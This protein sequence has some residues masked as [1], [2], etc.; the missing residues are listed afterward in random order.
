MS[1]PIRTILILT[2]ILAIPA[3]I[4]AQE[5]ESPAATATAT[6]TATAVTE[7]AE[8]G[9][10]ESA[11]ANTE[12]TVVTSYE[13]RE[14]FI[15]LLRQSPPD[16]VSILQLD[17]TLLS[18]QGFMNDYP[19][20]LAFV[21]T[22]P[23]VRR[24]PRFYVGELRE[25][26]PRRSLIGEV[27]ESLAIIGSLLL[28]AFSL[29]WFIRTVNEQK[30]WNRLFKTQNEVHNKILDRF[31]STDELLTYIKTPAGSKFLEA[32][33]IALHAERTPQSN[34]P[35]TRVLWSIQIGVVLAATAV[36]MLFV[37]LR[38]DPES[39]RE[40]F[41]LGMIAFFVGAGFI[42]SA[43]ASIFLSRRLGL[44]QDPQ[45]NQVPGPNPE[46]DPGL[47]R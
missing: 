21:E 43:V 11:E 1:L 18:N 4:H 45:S 13:I 22:H 5:A 30:R 47:M 9:A 3:G 35:M 19:E 40:L 20:L 25:P 34:P 42:G 44:W 28:A 33:P 27:I 6:E 12:Q 41:A 32:A 23:E 17:P 10:D 37:S 8:P 24:T 2:M 7:S 38:L 14:Q 26:A 16:L 15:A 46:H 39:S 31:G 29:G 36:G